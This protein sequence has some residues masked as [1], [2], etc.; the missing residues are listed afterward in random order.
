MNWKYN[1]VK[2]YLD[3]F[4]IVIFVPY[5]GSIYGKEKGQKKTQKSKT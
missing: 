4:K 2:F 5:F 1:Y 3:L